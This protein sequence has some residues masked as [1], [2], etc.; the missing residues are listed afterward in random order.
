[1]GG[2]SY[3]TRRLLCT[4]WGKGGAEL[5]RMVESEHI[6]SPI[7]HMSTY[8]L[9]KSQW[10]TN[11]SGLIKEAASLPCVSKA[12]PMHVR[13]CLNEKSHDTHGGEQV[14]GICT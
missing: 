7:H 3:P 13:N 9:E 4:P 2:G 10:Q 5:R 8:I 1:M 12:V 11:K 6:I 14:R